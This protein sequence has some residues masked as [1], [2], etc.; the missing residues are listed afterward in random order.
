MNTLHVFG[1]S[2]SEP[3]EPLVHIDDR[4]CNRVIYARDYLKS[5]TST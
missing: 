4:P 3:T 5:E 1:D 2:F